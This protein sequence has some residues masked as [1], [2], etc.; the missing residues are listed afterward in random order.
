MMRRE[1]GVALICSTTWLI[2]SI[3]EPSGAG[4]VPTITTHHHRQAG[5]PGDGLERVAGRGQGGRPHALEQIPDLL[6]AR[7]M[8]LKE[9]FT[10][11]A[12]V[13]Q[14]APGLVDRF[15]A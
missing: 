11:G 10:A 13:P 12:E 9:P 7:H 3:E 1:S 15:G 6:H 4:Q 2:W 14:P 8:L 5:D